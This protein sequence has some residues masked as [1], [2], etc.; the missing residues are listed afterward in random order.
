[1]ETEKSCV[2][3]VL[4]NGKQKNGASI[5]RMRRATRLTRDWYLVELV[6]SVEGERSE[7]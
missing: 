3:S 6:G 5:I 7:S 2:R 1:M 4:R